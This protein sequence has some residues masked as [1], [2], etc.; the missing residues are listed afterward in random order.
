MKLLVTQSCPTLC[1]PMDCSPPG[2]LVHGI[3]QARIWKWVTIPFSRTS[4]WPR[5]WSLV[6]CI[7]IWDTREAPYHK[8]ITH[9]ILLSFLKHWLSGFQA[10]MFSLLFLSYQYPFSLP[11]TSTSHLSDVSTMEF[12]SSILTFILI[13]PRSHLQIP[14]INW[15][16]YIFPMWMIDSYI[17]LFIQQIY[18]NV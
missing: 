17:Q 14:Y 18:W 1:N 9:L 2:S 3:F 7:A 6:S 5:A 12:L 11:F 15:W 4:S 16:R 13:Y 8:L 10:I